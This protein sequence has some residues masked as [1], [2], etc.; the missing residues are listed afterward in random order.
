MFIIVILLA[1]CLG[2]FEVVLSSHYCYRYHRKIEIIDFIPWISYKQLRGKDKLLI[3]LVSSLLN[4]S[5]TFFV[6]YRG[7]SFVT[8]LLTIVL[9][10][11]AII[12]YWLMIIPDESLI[13]LFIIGLLTIYFLPT[14]SFSNRLFGMVCCSGV[15]YIINL[16]KKNSFG[17]GDIKLM[18][19]LGFILGLNKSI[20][21]AY[22]S[23]LSA[24][25]AA[26][27]LLM[28]RHPKKIMPFGPFLSFSTIIIL[29]NL[30]HYVGIL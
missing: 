14:I 12:D 30:P 10:I 9:M 18:A 13:L 5:V 3:I 11:I 20:E 23:I 24:S 17:Y 28:C 26:I 25:L 6:F 8:L 15:M 29:L 19:V 2:Y 27:F 16:S 21:I 4:A 1:F 22:L 7:I